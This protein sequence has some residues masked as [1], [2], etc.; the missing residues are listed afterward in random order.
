VCFLGGGFFGAAEFAGGLAEVVVEAGRPD[1]A[2]SVFVVGG[3]HAADALAHE[4][5]DVG[6][7]GDGHLFDFSFFF[8]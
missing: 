2:F 1:E 4:G 8:F 5:G 3:E 6:F 7:E